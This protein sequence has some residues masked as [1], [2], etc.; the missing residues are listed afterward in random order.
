M[1]I[2]TIMCSIP[3]VLVSHTDLLNFT[4]ETLHVFHV[5]V[6]KRCKAVE[7]RKQNENV[8]WKHYGSYGA[9]RASHCRRRQ[10]QRDRKSGGQREHGPCLWE[11]FRPACFA[12]P[13]SPS[14]PSFHSTFTVESFTGFHCVLGCRNS[15]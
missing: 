5:L 3:I 9:I 13:C 1:L 7:G 14:L 10:G 2:L 6:E 12:A 8:S 15:G 4:C 11:A